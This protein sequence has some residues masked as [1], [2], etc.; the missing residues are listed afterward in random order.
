MIMSAQKAQTQSAR[1]KGKFVYSKPAET[2]SVE[3]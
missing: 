2:L 1:E 3:Q